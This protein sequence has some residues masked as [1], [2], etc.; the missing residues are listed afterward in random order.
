M[1]GKGLNKTA[2]VIFTEII[3]LAVFWLGLYT[4]GYFLAHYEYEKLIKAEPKTRT[5]VEDILFLYKS[6]NIGAEKSMWGK[7]YS[8]KEQ[9]YCRQY[10]ILLMNPIDVIYDQNDNVIRVFA[11]Y[12]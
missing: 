2:V 11:S 8:M 10:V 7:E 9:E 5:E 3:I 6:K 12:E 4:S 1:Q